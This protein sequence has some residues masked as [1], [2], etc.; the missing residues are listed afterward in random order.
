MIR[1]STIRTLAGMALAACILAPAVRANNGFLLISHDV[2]TQGRAGVDLAFA[3]DASAIASNPAGLA[4]IDGQRFDSVHGFAIPKVRWRG[5]TDSASD[6]RAIPTAAMFLA[7]DFEEPW[8]LGEALTF[9]PEG[10][11]S[12]YPSRYDPNYGSEEAGGSGIKIGLGIYPVAGSKMDLNYASPFWQPMD[13]SSNP[14]P[15]L[16]LEHVEHFSEFSIVAF[17]LAMAVRL[18]EHVAIGI[19]PSFLYSKFEADHPVAQPLSILA[20]RPVD[21]IPLTYGELAPFLGLNQIESNADI[22]DA[23][24]FGFHLK[25]GVLVNVNDSLS[26]GLTY[27][28]QSF[29]QDYLGK[30]Q[31]DFRRQVTRLDSLG[32]IQTATG[33]SLSD[34]TSY[35]G[36]YN[37]RIKA[38]DIPQQVG[39]GVGLRLLDGRISLGLD[40]KWLQWSETFDAFRAR[41]TNGTSPEINEMNGDGTTSASVEVPLEWKDQFVGAIGFTG[42]ISDNFAVRLGYNYGKSP[43]PVSTLQPDVP[44]ILEHHLTAGFSFFVR[45]LEVSFAVEYDLPSSETIANSRVNENYDGVEVE[46]EALFAQIGFGLRF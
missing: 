46:I 26:L 25:V 37:A 31:I 28:P 14:N 41:L 5:P 11:E 35:I 43:V 13:N 12:V 32:A 45:R 38:N 44:A 27:A 23:S 17:S 40:L 10:G 21:N 2:R 1:Y 24:T 8:H 30:S 29:M 16:P 3:D 36:D 39:F 19:T 4:F 7:F 34:P 18:N 6:S 9:E 20:G 33:V 42:Y 15:D 22:D